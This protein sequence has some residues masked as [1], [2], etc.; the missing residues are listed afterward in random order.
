[1]PPFLLPV[2]DTVSPQSFPSF[3]KL[4]VLMW[5]HCSG[6]LVH[7]L[8]W[9]CRF[10]SPLQLCVMPR[11]RQWELCYTS[12]KQCTSLSLRAADW[13]HRAPPELSRML[14]YCSRGDR[15]CN[16]YQACIGTSYSFSFR[17]TVS[18]SYTKPTSKSEAKFDHLSSIPKF[19]SAYV[20]V[21]SPCHLSLMHTDVSD[22]VLLDFLEP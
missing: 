6:L 11:N 9:D 12:E 16:Y 3:S 14:S 15:T 18:E 17:L 19:S 10:L 2:R 21:R 4:K 20:A 1:M 7:I 8:M 5:S 22:Q 13:D